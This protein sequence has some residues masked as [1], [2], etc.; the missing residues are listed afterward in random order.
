MKGDW[1]LFGC[2]ENISK[3]IENYINQS[4][5]K[6]GIYQKKYTFLIVWLHA[7][8]SMNEE[9]LQVQSSTEFH[10]LVSPSSYGSGLTFDCNRTVPLIVNMRNEA[11]NNKKD[12]TVQLVPKQNSPF[13]L[14][15]MLPFIY[16][17]S[18]KEQTLH[19][20]FG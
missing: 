6:K 11:E 14:L 15:T 16:R 20:N 9:A 13:K 4:G 2:N 1:H 17:T 12:K 3:N 19:F 5:G 18:V 8:C 10:P 7:A